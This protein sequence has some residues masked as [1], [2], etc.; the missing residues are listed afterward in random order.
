MASSN[1][2]ASS[3]G[4]KYREGGG[5]AAVKFCRREGWGEVDAGGK[6]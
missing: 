6:R 1:S 4:R 5:R 3:L 2:E